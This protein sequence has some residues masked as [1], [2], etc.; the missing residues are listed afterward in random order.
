MKIS[1]LPIDVGFDLRTLGMVVHIGGATEVLYE[2]NNGKQQTAT[3]TI[4]QIATE[5]KSAGFKVKRNKD[6]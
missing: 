5:L 3:G 4:E 6:E 2:D 1:L